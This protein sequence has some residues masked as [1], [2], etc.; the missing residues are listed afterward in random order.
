MD[1]ASVAGAF[2]RAGD[3]CQCT[4]PNCPHPVADN[5]DTNAQPARCM[6]E[7]QAQDPAG[8][9]LFG[10]QLLCQPCYDRGSMSAT[11]FPGT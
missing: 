2:A 4:S 5:V 6:I 8:W 11:V 1:E 3:R 10:D 7:L 9:Q